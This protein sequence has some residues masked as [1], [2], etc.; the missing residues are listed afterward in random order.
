M[1]NQFRDMVIRAIVWDLR[2]NNVDHLNQPWK[3]Q[4]QRGPVVIL[5]TIHETIQ[6]L[7]LLT[8]NLPTQD[9]KQRKLKML[10]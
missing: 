1:L 6:N 10:K 7:I 2:Y 3:S 5:L 4:I 9:L 8:L